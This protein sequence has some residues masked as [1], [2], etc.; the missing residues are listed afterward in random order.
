MEFME[1]G[2]TINAEV[3]C[4]TLK[5][6]RRAI[7]NKRRG[8]LTSEVVF[9]HDNARPHTAR[10]MTALV[11]SFRWEQFSHPPYSPDL[12]LSNFHLFL[13]MKKFLAGQKFESDDE[14]KG[15]VQQLSLIH[16]FTLSFSY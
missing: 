9:V 6:L 12:A 3:Y 14:I 8:L 13:H 1:R 15:N 7:Q 11:D 16:I 10:V 5:K 2:T 4:E